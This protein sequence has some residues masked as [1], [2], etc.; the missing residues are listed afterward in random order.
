MTHPVPGQAAHELDAV[1]I[2]RIG[3][4]QQRR[5]SDC[6]HALLI[7]A[8]RSARQGFARDD[9]SFADRL[10]TLAS[11]PRL[12]SDDGRTSGLGTADR[13]AA[14]ERYL[15]VLV[16]TNGDASPQCGCSMLACP[17]ARSTRMPTFLGSRR[18]RCLRQG[19]AT[20]AFARG[21]ARRE[22]RLGVDRRALLRHRHRPR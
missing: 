13:T 16:M 12:R 3:T 22:G 2:G 10:R 14:R 11:A 9:A 20:F 4:K 19:S 6:M 15:G 17:P 8:V 5:G 21:D 1:V 7:H 18:S